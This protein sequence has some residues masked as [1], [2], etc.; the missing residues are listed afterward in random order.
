MLGGV[1][2]AG[3]DGGRDAADL[4]R[5]V[6]E[7]VQDLEPSGLARTFSVSAWSLVISSMTR[8]W[9][10][11]RLRMSA[12][13]TVQAGLP[14]AVRGPIRPDPPQMVWFASASSAAVERWRASGGPRPA[15]HRPSPSGSRRRRQGPRLRRSRRHP[16]SPESARHVAP[17]GR[18]LPSIISSGTADTTS[19]SPSRSRTR[20]QRIRHESMTASAFSTSPVRMR[21]TLGNTSRT[22]KAWFGTAPASGLAPSQRQPSPRRRGRNRSSRERPNAAGR[23]WSASRAAEPVALDD[24]GIERVG[25]AV[26]QGDQAQVRKGALELAGQ[27]A[28]ARQVAPERRLLEQLAGLVRAAVAEPVRPERVAREP[29]RAGRRRDR[30]VPVELVAQRRI[31]R[32]GNARGRRG[33]EAPAAQAAERRGPAGEEYEDLAGEHRN[34]QGCAPVWSA[35]IP[36]VT[37]A[38][39]TRMAVTRLAGAR[40]SAANQVAT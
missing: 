22:W 27:L 19:E 25:D 14:G 1:R 9:T 4:E 29:D 26:A 35:W 30:A 24:V 38:P 2:L 23:T 10:Y 8:A 36:A 16:P 32:S 17:R 12:E 11:A 6:R 5:S 21:P 33:S 37:G 15:A 28:E 3:A 40:C 13:R 31:G 20:P 34:L 18:S 7:P 39:S